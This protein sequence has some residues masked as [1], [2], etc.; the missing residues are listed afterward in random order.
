MRQT[1][2]FTPQS[3]TTGIRL[4]LEPEASRHLL[5]VLRLRTGAEITVFNGDGRDYAARLA[6][7]ERKAAVLEIGEP[8]GLEPAPALQIHLGLGISR[9]ERMDFAIQKAVE[10]GVSAITPLFTERSVVRL[11]GARL[12][13]RRG[14]WQGVVIGACEQ[15][16]R[17]RLPELHAASHLPDWLDQGHAGGL[18]LDHRAGTALPQMNP[19]RDRFT[20]LV[21]PE[22]GLAP[23]EQEAARRTGFIGV[24]LGPRVLRTET[25]PLAAL[26]AIQALWGDFR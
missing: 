7:V 12:E 5:Q 11:T 21:G 2:V 15:S 20:L 4:T 3:L 22:G 23:V 14:H 13:K 25:A 24:R 6:S 18:L 17:R 1:R 9:G 19:T 16:G 8:S 26:A 10:L